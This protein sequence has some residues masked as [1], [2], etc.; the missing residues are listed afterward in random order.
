L[1]SAPQYVRAALAY[2]LSGSPDFTHV[3]IALRLWATTDDFVVFAMLTT[4]AWFK[5]FLQWL[6]KHAS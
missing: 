2:T 6:T 1:K 4:V 5:I 3:I